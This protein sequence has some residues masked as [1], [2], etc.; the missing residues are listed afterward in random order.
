MEGLQ[1]DCGFTAKPML[2]HVPGQPDLR[3]KGVV[4]RLHCVNDPSYRN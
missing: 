3:L 1:P 4:E 2:K